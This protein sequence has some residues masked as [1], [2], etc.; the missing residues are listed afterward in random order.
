MLKQWLDSKG[1]KYTN[2]NVDSNPIAAQYMV[3][4]SK[5]TGVPFSVIEKDDGI[6]EYILGFDRQKFESLL[7]KN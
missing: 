4:L 6:E 3:H 7:I 5:Q 1:V 2:Y